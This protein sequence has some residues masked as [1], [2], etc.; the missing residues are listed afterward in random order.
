M[1]K[2]L[3]IDYGE[4]KIGLAIADSLVAEPLKVVSSLDGVVSEIRKNNIEKIVVG[5]SEGESA[6]KAK[7]FG[8]ILQERVGM[9]VVFQDET[10]S[11]QE[12]QTLAMEAGIKRKKRKGMED[13]FAAALILQN[14]LDNS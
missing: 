10:L 1:T 9:E 5:I 14:Y 12:A 4:K 8:R 3:G 7:A 11:T 6:D 2:L 13:A